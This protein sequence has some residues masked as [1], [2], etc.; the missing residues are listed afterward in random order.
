M[1]SHAVGPAARNRRIAE[2]EEP[3]A[4]LA[5]LLGGDAGLRLGEILAL[6]WCDVNFA[7]GQ[8]Q[9]QCSDWRG[10]IG[11]PKSGKPR[12]IPMTERLAAALRA[13]RA[14]GRAGW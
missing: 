9:I 4:H 5:V 1:R 3:A 12:I 10:T 6:Q 2:R 13:H 11:L 8:L 7:R 14:S